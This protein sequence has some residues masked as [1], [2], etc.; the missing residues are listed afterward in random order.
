[1]Q[2]ARRYNAAA[3]SISRQHR[4][5]VTRASALYCCGYSSCVHRSLRSVIHHLDYTFLCC[6]CDRSTLTVDG[7]LRIIWIKYEYINGINISDVFCSS[8][9]THLRNLDI[10]QHAENTNNITTR[11]AAQAAAGHTTSVWQVRGVLLWLVALS[12]AAIRHQ[13]S[14]PL[15]FAVLCMCVRCVARLARA[16]KNKNMDLWQYGQMVTM[17]D[18]GFDGVSSSLG[19]FMSI[20]FY[21]QFFFQLF[22][23]VC[24]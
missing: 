8:P 22:F 18:F 9:E 4:A 19:E 16:A 14:P 7:K 5:C 3:V 13:S 15:S 11:L 20:L 6:C 2:R 10:R 23:V 21:F 17:P 24:T 1:M 12:E